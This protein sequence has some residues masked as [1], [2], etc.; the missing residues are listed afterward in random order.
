MNLKL[1]QF[2]KK[3]KIAII[4]TLFFLFVFL[5]HQFLYL[6]FDDYGYAS[7]SYAV[8]DVNAVGLNYGISEIFEF[9]GKHY[10]Q[11]G[12][13]ILFY[14]AE[15]VL[16]KIGLPFYRLFQSICITIIF[17]Y[18]YL[19]INKYINK[20]KCKEINKTTL[21]ILIVLFYGVVSISLVNSGIFWISASVSYLVP[22]AFFLPFVYYLD[23]YNKYHF[24]K[25]LCKFL[26]TIG[27]GSLIFISS[28]SQEQLSTMAVCYIFLYTIYYSFKNKK[29]NKINIIFCIISLLGFAIL[30]LA[31]GN[32]VRMHESSNDYFNS[33][34]FFEKILTNFPTL[35]RINFSMYYTRFF[36]MI[37]FIA[38]LYMAYKNK[39]ENNF[40]NSLNVLSLVSSILIVSISIFT[41][42]YYFDYILQYENI[43]AT[44]IYLY[45][46]I[47]IQL[48]LMVYTTVIYLLKNDQITI[49]LIY[50]SAWASQAVML[51][52]PTV[53]NRCA[54]PFEFLMFILFACVFTNIIN[55]SKT[56]IGLYIIIC[57]AIPA[58]IN[59]CTITNGYYQNNEANSY[60][61]NQLEI[62]AE[63]ISTGEKIESIRLKKLKNDLYS[64]T[65]PYM[66]GSDYIQYW[67]K[68]Y[69]NIPYEVQLI[70]E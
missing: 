10:M 62:M 46:L 70:Y 58:T 18:I 9:L 42:Y 3:Y 54:I 43:D 37:Y 40:N 51:Y 32:S 60:N 69:Y 13:R 7:L 4:F 21:A 49:I 17:Y 35:V 8:S 20:S 36:T 41:N 23:I 11:W 52:S 39:I 16:L 34:S 67:I 48:L 6:H 28:F 38:Y 15:V 22:L 33:L 27:L 53:V 30:M 63:K 25:K 1:K 26:A 19:L 64:S 66:P 50:L 24:K 5:Q 14:F 59:Y 56:K 65:Q 29:I 68:E 55:S 31:P 2:Y 47:L 61:N 57:T 45:L 12:G 44:R